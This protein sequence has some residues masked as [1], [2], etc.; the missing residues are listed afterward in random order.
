MNVICDQLAE[1]A[2]EVSCSQASPQDLV[3]SLDSPNWDDPSAYHDWRSVIP[4]IEDV[5]VEIPMVARLAIFI[6]ATQLAK[7]Y[8]AGE[9]S[10]LSTFD[11]GVE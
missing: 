10:A 2:A 5:W 11:F 9:S 6:L 3:A 1:S 8:S 7:A 4:D